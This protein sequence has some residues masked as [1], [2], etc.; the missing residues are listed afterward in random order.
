MGSFASGLGDFGQPGFQS[1]QAILA[2]QQAAEKQAA[3][4]Q[5]QPAASSGIGTALTGVGQILGAIGTVGA[6]FYQ[7]R[8]QAEIQKEMLKLQAQQP[9]IAAPVFI[10]PPAQQSSLPLIL[11]IIAVFGVVGFI[12]YSQTQDEPVY[13]PTPV[14]PQPGADLQPSYGPPPPRRRIIRRRRKK[15]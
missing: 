13:G 7:A 3:A 9:Q 15:P 12:I 11:G 4:Q 6:Q 5:Q 14:A 1:A 8:T 2:E 10:P